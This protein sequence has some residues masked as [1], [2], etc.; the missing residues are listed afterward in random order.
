MSV[1]QF[2]GPSNVLSLLIYCTAD[3]SLMLTLDNAN[4]DHWM[5]S[6]KADTNVSWSRL[7]GK[8]AQE[9]IKAAVAKIAMTKLR[10]YADSWCQIISKAAAF[11]QN[12][13]PGNREKRYVLSLR[14]PV[15]RRCIY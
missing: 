4:S 15:E 3:N 14:V 2:E 6:V 10:C 5:P 13:V 9:V 1:C 12:L 8:E 11:K 7:I